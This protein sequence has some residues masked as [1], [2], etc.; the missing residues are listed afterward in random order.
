MTPEVVSSWFTPF[1]Y[2]VYLAAVLVIMVVFYQWQWAK[3]CKNNVLVLVVHSDASSHY[4]LSPKT[5]GSVALKSPTSDTVRMWPINK[6]STIVVQYPGVGWVPGFLQ[7]QISMVIVDEDDWEPLLNRGSYNEKVASPD[8]VA[9]LKT[10]ADSDGVD[11]EMQ[12]KLKAIYEVLST[13][14]T[15]EMVAS[16]A[17]LGNLMHEKITEAVIT[18]NKEMLDSIS[19]LMRRLGK[20]VNPTVVYIGLG[21]AVVLLIFIVYQVVPAL[22]GMEDVADDVNAIKRSLGISTPPAP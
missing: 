13:A 7:K 22:S 15:R 16:P 1:H 18:V 9:A 17:L 5:G 19:G 4:L 8:V 2:F 21:L 14:P 10:I 12:N 6:L 20:L 11:E 3:T